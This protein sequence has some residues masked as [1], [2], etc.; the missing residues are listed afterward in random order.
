MVPSVIVEITWHVPG[1]RYHSPS[2]ITAH[3]RRC[4]AHQRPDQCRARKRPV[5]ILLRRTPDISTRREGPPRVPD[6]YR[7]THLPGRLPPGGYRADL[8]R[9][10]ELRHSE[11][12]RLSHRRRG[13]VLRTSCDPRRH[14]A[15]ARGHGPSTTVAGSGLEPQRSRRALGP[16]ARH[17]PQGH[18]PGAIDQTRATSTDGVSTGKRLPGTTSHWHRQIQAS[19]PRRRGRDGHSVHTAG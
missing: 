19:R 8:R 9:V 12:Q 4:H 3:R 5:D 16:E 1:G 2:I 14:G 6:V 17:T 15:D 7:P 10:E 18:P 13:R 11:R